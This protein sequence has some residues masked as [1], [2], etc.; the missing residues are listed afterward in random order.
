MISKE[1]DEFFK[2]NHSIKD[3]RSTDIYDFGR[4]KKIFLHEFPRGRDFNHFLREAHKEG[5]LKQII[6]NHYVN[7]AKYES[8]EW[9]FYRKDNLKVSN[10]I[11]SE[12]VIT[13]SKYFKS[14]RN[15]PTNN[16]DFV[17]SYQEQ[18]IY[19][20]LL[21]EVGFRFFYERSFGIKGYNKTPDFIIVNLQSKIVFQWEHFG[22]TNNVS[23]DSSVMEKIQWYLDK[24]YRFIENG[25]RFI[26]THYIN[27]SS[28]HSDIER[29]IG[30][31]KNMK[32]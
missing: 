10:E 22:M 20:R 8:F 17:R 5:I 15:I 24:G 16:G 19:N 25:G 26:V 27:E 9:Y 2:T 3:V 30:L 32:E 23:Y 13:P 7:T 29:I 4:R 6:T 31:I 28:F 11:K 14:E 21:K 18:Y 1:I 12:S